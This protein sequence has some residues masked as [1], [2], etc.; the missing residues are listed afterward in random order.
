VPLKWRLTRWLYSPP[1]G[2]AGLVVLCNAAAVVAM[3][4]AL[5]GVPQEVDTTLNTYRVRGTP[6]ARPPLDHILPSSLDTGRLDFEQ[7]LN[8]RPRLMQWKRLLRYH[9]VSVCRT[10]TPGEVR[11]V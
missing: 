3:V 6:A 8:P 4:M 9:V 10:T 2:A 11:V 1:G 7:L 5:A